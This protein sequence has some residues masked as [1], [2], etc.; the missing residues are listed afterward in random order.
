MM[1]RILQFLALL[2]FSVTAYS[3]TGYN[4][5]A[6]AYVTTTISQNVVF[7]S[8]MQQG[9]TFSFSV[10]AHNGGGR[11]GQSDTANV[12]IEFYNSSGGLVSQV[13]TSYN[14]NLPN[15][16][17]ICGNPCI[18]TSVPWTTLTASTTLTAAQAGTV[19]YAK[20]SMYGIDGSYWAG[21]YGPWYRAPTF[22]LNGGGNLAYNPE[23]GPYNNITAQ[24]WTSNPGF[25]ACQGAWGGSNACIVNSDGVPGSS[26]VGLVANANGGGPDIL[27]GT[28]S[29]TAGGYNSTMTVTNAGTGA[30]AGA[31][32]TPPAPTVTGTSVTY[33]TR[34]ATTG[35]TTYSYRTPVTVTTWSDGTT[36]STNGTEVLTNTAVTSTIVTNRVNGST[37]TT[38][39]TP[40]VTN[41]P[42][43]GSPSIAAN[44]QQTSTSQQ[45]QQGLNYKVHDF[46]AYTYNCGIFGCL[47][48]LL[49]P[50]VV[51]NLSPNHYSTNHTG[52]TSSGVYV[53]TN[54]SFPNMGDGTLVAYNGTITAPITSTKPAG[55]IYRIYFY[56]NNDDGFVMKING[57]GVID[58]RSTFQMQAL[59]TG[60]TASGYVDLVAG[61]TYNFEAWYWND[62]GGY[63]LKLM[64][65]IGTGRV[66]V[67]NSAFT[68]GTIDN[69][70]IDTTGLAYTNDAI[71]PIAGLCCG[72]TATPFDA[73]ASNTTKVANYVNRTTNDSRVYIEQVGNANTITVDQSGTKNNF[74][75][76][77]GDGSSNTVTVTQT[78]N[79]STQ[80]NYADISIVGSSNAVNITQT[81]TG[82]AK[83][84][85]VNILD[86]N[87]SVIIQQRDSG[88]HYADVILSGGNKTV[89]I[90]QQ[91]SAGHMASVT[92]SGT[93]TSLSLT[94][95]GNTQNFYSI[96]HNCATAGGCAPIS[97]TQ[98][99]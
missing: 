28:T 20:I 47:R 80:V 76:Y 51:P 49:G 83:G 19:A 93:P 82:G 27:G 46:D 15:P 26:T 52:K 50:Y 7:N 88:S 33:T 13:A 31:P 36:T 74:V 21:D 35:N 61:Q 86:N 65:D 30:T 71:V 62:T 11:A 6:T 73:D 68:T 56:S 57:T 60:Y 92:L 91:G 87:N 41:T 9:G 81:S 4:A 55:T 72:G 23:F 70:V 12:K 90:L 18:D 1:T 99:N 96:S 42:A 14:A 79:A 97:V 32:S 53:P 39:T 22:Q 8:T 24:G 94:Q 38:Y 44:G 59:G 75:K 29:G 45:V 25:G 34:T 54:G 63:G 16:N 67:P 48:N 40:I 37:L 2:V 64:W 78:G 3:Q 5:I 77:V 98:G 95:S 84:A 69:V 10:L 66:L 58:D 17:A 43:G 89:N 85:F